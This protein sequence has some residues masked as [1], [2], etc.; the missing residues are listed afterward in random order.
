MKKFKKYVISG[1]HLM[2]NQLLI[3]IPSAILIFLMIYFV[4]NTKL[5]PAII[6][7]LVTIIISW[8]IWAKHINFELQDSKD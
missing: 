7:S 1:S 8:I 3:T 6:Y 2:V 5:L 4:L